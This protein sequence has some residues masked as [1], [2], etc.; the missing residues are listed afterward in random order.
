MHN[1][2]SL[3]GGVEIK[4]FAII[5][6]ETF[7]KFWYMKFLFVLLFFNQVILINIY[8]GHLH[9]FSSIF[10]LVIK[11]FSFDLHR[12]LIKM[13]VKKTHLGYEPPRSAA[14]DQLFSLYFGPN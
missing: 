10:S 8:F 13:G 9:A 1:G 5:Q 4:N 11:I 7:E 12:I 2:N 3:K 14:K 6:V